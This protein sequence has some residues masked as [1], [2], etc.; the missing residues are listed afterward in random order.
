MDEQ[1]IQDFA[2]CSERFSG[3]SELR[4]LYILFIHVKHLSLRS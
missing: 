4:I 1:D 3:S 2:G